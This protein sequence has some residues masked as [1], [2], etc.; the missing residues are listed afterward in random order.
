MKMAMVIS[1]SVVVVFESMELSSADVSA[2][3]NIIPL[4]VAGKKERIL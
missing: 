3:E 4:G 1:S 2:R